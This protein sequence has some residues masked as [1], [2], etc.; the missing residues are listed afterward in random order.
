MVAVY[1][2]IWHKLGPY[3]ILYN[4]VNRVEYGIEP[5]Y[6]Y[7]RISHFAGLLWHTHTLHTRAQTVKIECD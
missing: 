3:K 1:Y 6:V 7:T 2:R 4:F 5:D